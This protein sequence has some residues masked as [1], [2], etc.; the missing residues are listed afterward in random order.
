M[1]TV[2]GSTEKPLLSS[3][4]QELTDLLEVATKTRLQEEVFSIL[5]TDHGRI[6][7]IINN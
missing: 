5:K 4:I 1:N 7:L 2:F 6:Q 3:K